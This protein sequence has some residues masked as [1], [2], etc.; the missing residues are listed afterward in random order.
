[1]PADPNEIIWAPIPIVLR[2]L[3][4]L[5]F[6]REIPIYDATPSPRASPGSHQARS[7]R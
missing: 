7:G 2:E 1:M 5:V 6:E 3:M 4:P